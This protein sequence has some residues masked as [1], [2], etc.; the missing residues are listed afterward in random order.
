MVNF[1][2]CA[3]TVGVVSGVCFTLLPSMITWVLDLRQFLRQRVE[4]T[5]KSVHFGVTALFSLSTFL[6]SRVFDNTFSLTHF[7]LC[8]L[9]LPVSVSLK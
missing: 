9:I 8:P 2:A 4:H 1:E 5:C 6:I 7:F 3:V